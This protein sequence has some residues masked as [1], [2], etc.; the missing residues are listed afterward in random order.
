[1]ENQSF[2]TNHLHKFLFIIVMVDLIHNLFIIVM[3][4]LKILMVFS[5]YSISAAE[6]PATSVIL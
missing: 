6:F 1:M 5:K 3:V 4:D 2:V